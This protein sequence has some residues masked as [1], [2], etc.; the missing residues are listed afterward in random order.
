MPG[1]QQEM[2]RTLKT[3]DQSATTDM[4]RVDVLRK[5]PEVVRKLGG[6]PNALLAKARIDPDILSNR[7]AVLPYRAFAK[8]LDQAALDL[9]R[10]DF[11]MYLASAQEGPKVLGPL[12]VAMRN[13]ATLRTA[14]AYGASHLQ[15]FSTATRIL[16][17][18]DHDRGTTLLRFDVKSRE[19]QQNPQSAEH[20]LL[21][22]QHSLRDFSAQKVRAHEVWFRHDAVAAPALYADYFGAPVKFGQ[23]ANA[24]LLAAGELDT[25]IPGGNPLLHELATC[26]IDVNYP[27]NEVD[28]SARIGILVEQRIQDGPCTL[29]DIAAALGMQPR[30]LQRQ[31]KA[32]GES[33]EAIRDNVRRD[34]AL[35]YLKQ[36]DMPLIRISELLGYSDASML[37][38][39]CHRWFAA[40]PRQIR[41]G[42]GETA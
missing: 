3:P 42:T 25:A 41:A 15:V 35:R 10:P 12:E 18:E 28:L 17:D 9:A 37:T 26:F 7:H 11:G 16:I 34:L 30:T 19:L 8:L 31:L 36:S 29:S 33:F 1:A 27:P 6:N 32:I 20:G 5:F 4:V 14:F 40:S 39:S 13:S 23:A 21:L 2:D 38:R 22:V 24:L